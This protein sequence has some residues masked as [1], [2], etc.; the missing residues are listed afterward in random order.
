MDSGIKIGL[1]YAIIQALWARETASFLYDHTWQVGCHYCFL[2]DSR[3]ETRRFTDSI[4][5]TPFHRIPRE[6]CR[7]GIGSAKTCVLDEHARYETYL[8]G[9]SE[10]STRVSKED[11]RSC[12]CSPSTSVSI[13]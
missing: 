12:L 11:H 1:S 9:R 6:T 8:I 10:D 5:Q 13:C 3:F 7:H 4:S 2:P